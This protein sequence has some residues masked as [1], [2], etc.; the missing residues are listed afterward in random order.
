LLLLMFIIFL[1]LYDVAVTFSRS[2][3]FFKNSLTMTRNVA[4]QTESLDHSGSRS[5]SMIKKSSSA[6]FTHEILDTFGELKIEKD[7]VKQ[8]NT[9]L[10]I[11]DVFVDEMQSVQSLDISGTSVGAVSLN[12]VGSGSIG[13]TSS[14]SH[15][16]VTVAHSENAKYA[17]KKQYLQKSLP[18]KLYGMIKSPVSPLAK[19]I[20]MALVGQSIH[21]TSPHQV[22]H[23]ERQRSPSI[24]I[25]IKQPSR[26][27]VAIDGVHF[28]DADI[29]GGGHDK[30]DSASGFVSPSSSV[31][32]SPRLQALDSDD[33]SV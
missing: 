7:V 1:L 13:S 17:K 3:L 4:T 11:S 18:R 24:P 27:S 33:L 28:D 30:E 19:D 32:M 10:P 31:S 21:A 23:S 15:N 25:L 29:F 9:D 16:R 8:K 2:L 20:T 12:F 6:G 26:E 22:I 14:S 5:K